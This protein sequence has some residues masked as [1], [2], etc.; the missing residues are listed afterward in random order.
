M[1]DQ[2]EQIQYALNLLDDSSPVVQKEVESELL[3]NAYHLIFHKKQ[4]L[5]NA[6][7]NRKAAL[8]NWYD[9][10]HF[11]LVLRALEQIIRMTP[12]DVDL[13]AA[14]I[15]LA[16]WNNPEIQP[17]K[18]VEKLDSL[19]E[20]VSERYPGELS[21]ESQVQHLSYYLY[22]KFGLKGNYTD[23]YH[24]DNSFLDRVLE[25]KKGIPILLSAITMLVGKRL[26]IHLTGIPMP[27]H[28]ILK[29]ESNG[30]AVF[31]D[32]FY[33]GKIYTRQEC[34]SYLIHANA[35][36]PTAVLE[37]TTHARILIRVMR[38]IHL[39]Y[40]S[41]Q[42]QPQKVREISDFIELVSSYFSLEEQRI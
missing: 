23:Y 34:I 6:A 24:P 39:V 40:S 19:A 36:D 35:A 30:E 31:F 37:G 32:P 3:R 33:Q 13:E 4:Y 7:G 25:N 38:N 8:Q 18:L 41:Y 42:D 21:V 9:A 10:H 26:G 29:Y 16:Y 27:A 11:P 20:M 5:S 28:F 15:L 1:Q 14:L 12:E 17:E 2:F 22:K